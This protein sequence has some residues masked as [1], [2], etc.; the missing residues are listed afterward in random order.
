[1]KKRLI[2][3]SIIS[4]VIVSFI[5]PISVSAHTLRTSNNSIY[6]EYLMPIS[7]SAELLAMKSDGAYYL[8]ANIDLT[9]TDWVP[10]KNF[11]GILDG[12]GYS[13]IGLKSETYGLFRNLTGNAALKNLRLINTQIA[14][15]HRTVGALAGYVNEKGAVQI[16]VTNCYVN[17]YVGTAW[18]HNW[19]DYSN[20]N[21]YAGALIGAVY[22]PE[23]FINECYSD[24]LVFCERNA[25]GLV[26]LN[27]GTIQKS[28][29]SGEI[30]NS[31]NTDIYGTR[32]G[33]DGKDDPY[34]GMKNVGGIT[35]VNRG[36]IAI[37]YSDNVTFPSLVNYVGGITGRLEKGAWIWASVNNSAVNMDYQNEG[38][39][40]GYASKDA[41][42]TSCAYIKGQS[43]DVNAI[44]KT[45]GAFKVLELDKLNYQNKAEADYFNFN[46]TAF[47]IIALNSISDLTKLTAEHYDFANDWYKS[48]GKVT[49]RSSLPYKDRYTVWDGATLRYDF[50]G[51]EPFK[52]SE[53]EI[54]VKLTTVKAYTPD[55]WDDD[56]ARGY[57]RNPF[58]DIVIHNIKELNDFI[59][60][61]KYSFMGKEISA[62]LK[63]YDETFFK[64]KNL[65]FN[66]KD[67]NNDEY[68][69][70]MLKTRKI[71]E[72]TEKGTFGRILFD[73]TE[74]AWNN[75]TT[76]K[77]GTGRYAFFIEVKKSDFTNVSDKDIQSVFF[78]Y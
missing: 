62:Q 39:V 33:E 6:T 77:D 38:A 64:S 10:V 71:T 7:T 28:A 9:D 21:L 59:D 26:G 8:T 30:M 31:A 4:L 41:E 57:D 15:V 17:G 29:F 27:Y 74:Q 22:S 18:H 40:A 32:K 24:A 46:S 47:N 43:K 50:N 36:T 76:D 1:M 12:N 45:A 78:T 56:M 51:F 44:G 68:E 58:N 73:F 23:V 60:K 61:V 48:G 67:K 75:E 49:L 20:K 66:I 3:V 63:K 42:I 53:K 37:C 25:G 65:Y 13:I 72:T 14:S 54:S 70:P 55:S 5:M 69:I 35:A 16:T 52:Y 19:Q 11:S 2:I 34:Y